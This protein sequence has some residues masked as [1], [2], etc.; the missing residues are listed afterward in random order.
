MDRSAQISGEINRVRWEEYETAYGD[1][2]SI[3]QDLKLLLFGSLEQA[4]ESS[5]RL[6][7]ALCHQHA[8]V[9]TA[10]EPAVPFILIALNC[11]DD[12]LKVEILD[13]LLGFVVC[14]DSA[15]PHTISVAKKLNESKELFS[16]L[17]GS[18]S[19]EVGKFAKDIHGQLECT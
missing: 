15:A 3:P 6:W 17:A 1:A 7:C 14:R 13:I 4:M 9:S 19:K 16:V 5:H 11:A 12:N 8:F 10:A 2:T 18:R